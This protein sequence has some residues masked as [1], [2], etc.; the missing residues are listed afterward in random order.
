MAARPGGAGKIIKL[1]ATLFAVTA[2]TGC[3]LGAVNAVTLE[4]IR[5]AKIQMKN[6]ALRSVMPDA[7][8]FE[9]WTI[10]SAEHTELVRDVQAA[11]RGGAVA[12]WCITVAPKGYGGEVET[13][14]GIKTDGTVRGLDILSHK[15]TPGLGAKAAE[16]WFKAQFA[17]KKFSD[18]AE[19]EINAISGATRTSRAVASGVDAALTY[20]KNHLQGRE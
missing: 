3:V 1:G 20:W 18:S 7:D 19:Y 12:G 14:V 16:P 17:D 10:G 13:V 4:P 2:I 15:E 8:S 6:D 9:E 5:Q 11:R